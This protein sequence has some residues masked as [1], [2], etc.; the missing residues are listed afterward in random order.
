LE[1]LTKLFE[2]N[3]PELLARIELEKGNNFLFQFKF[4]KGAFTK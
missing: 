4:N 2:I 3:E 1:K